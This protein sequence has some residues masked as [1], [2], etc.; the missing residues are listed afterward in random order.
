MVT[1]VNN[2][3]P[4]YYGLSTDVKPTQYVQNGA[5]FIEM[6]TDKLYLFDA[7]D[8]SWNEWGDS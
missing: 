5:S 6:D 2:D 3:P 8:S 7:S 1:F 4:T